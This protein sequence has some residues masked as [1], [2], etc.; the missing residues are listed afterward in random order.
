MSDFKRLLPQSKPSV[1]SLNRIVEKVGGVGVHE[2]KIEGEDPDAIIAFIDDLVV[3]LKKLPKKYVRI[4]DYRTKDVKNFFENHKYLYVDNQDL[5][6]I[7]ERLRKKIEYEKLA[8]NPFFFDL[9]DEEVTFDISD[10]EDKYRSK[11]SEHE[12]YYKGYLFSTDRKLA[13]VL[14]HP[15]GTTTGTK[16]SKELSDT[17]S[18]TV[19][20]LNPTSYH[21]SINIAYGGKFLKVL[22]QYEQLIQDML[23]TLSLCL[24]FVAFVLFLY[25]RRVRV[26]II[27]TC[28]LTVGS[29]WAFALAQIFI[30]SLNSQTAFL[31]SIIVGNGVNSGIF[32]IARYLEERKRSTP[33]LQAI[34][35]AVKRTY[36]STFTAAI[37]T[38]VAFIALSRSEI[39]GM[40]EFGFI[41]GVGMILCWLASYTFIPAILS[42]TEKYIPMHK[43]ASKVTSNWSGIFSKIESIIQKKYRP[44]VLGSLMLLVTASVLSVRFIP[45]SLE[46]DFSN[47]KNKYKKTVQEEKRS[48]R[49]KTIF[50]ESLNPSIILLD[51]VSQA[52]QLCET[53]M[54]LESNLHES[55]KTISS[56]KRLQDFVPDEQEDKLV[57]LGKIRKLLDDDTVKPFYKEYKADIEELRKTKDYEVITMDRLPD[58]MKRKY[59]EKDGK[60]GRL[61]FVYSNK[62]SNI[63][64]GKRL[65][66]HTD[67]L[68]N[69]KLEDGGVVSISG[70]YP[71]FSDLLKAIKRDGPIVSLLSFLCVMLLIIFYFRNLKA[72]LF[73]VGSLVFS[74]ILLF[75]I[76]S[77]F[78]IKL[79]FFNYIALPVT[80]GI[81]VDYAVNLFHRYRLEGKGKI[82]YALRT[83]GGAIVL[84]SMTT[85]IGY[86]SLTQGI[87]Q[88]MVSFGWLA[89]IGEVSC[90]IAGLLM[91]PS[92]LHYWDLKKNTL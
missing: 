47:L 80:F 11:T 58:T 21:P 32:L 61:A 13:M 17:I 59:Q 29:A 10:I 81:G 31:G 30:G 48:E 20:S 73:I 9:E 55:E 52:D 27:L 40:S 51:N 44:I 49:Q 54:N 83:T 85:M 36:F 67:T 35:S 41:G 87:N 84:C 39:Q 69:I 19:E 76:Q 56:C 38:S 72:I 6:T 71:I 43:D 3:E 63:S 79:N 64:N 65:I 92:I 15:S 88:A 42:L 45:T 12:K 90:I 4:V 7:E 50:G 78:Q 8:Q 62:N 18:N 24:F 77:I 34:E 57:T 1:V 46:Y 16:F 53:V 89:F 28:A 2:I 37:T 68:T 82:L 26:I 60:L 66:R 70:D 22:S 5:M 86:L 33:Y 74:T 23:E 14:I 91:I 25:F 75:G